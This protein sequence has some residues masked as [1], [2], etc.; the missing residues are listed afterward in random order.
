MS[1]L[2]QWEDEGGS[3]EPAYESD[4]TLHLTRTDLERLFVIAHFTASKQD[5]MLMDR[6]REALANG[7][8]TH[9]H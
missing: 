7:D 5:Q 9:R 6:F 8:S 3:F 2:H 4:V 1:E